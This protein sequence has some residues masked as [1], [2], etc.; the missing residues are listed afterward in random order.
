MFQL[1][2]GQLTVDLLD[3]AAP[4]DRARLGTRYCWGGYIWQVRDAQAGPLLAGPEWP[5]PTPIAFNGQGL[6]ESFRHAE[7]GTGRPLILENNRGFII[8]IG[9]V[10]LNMAGELAVEQPCAWTIT[11][12]ADAVEFCTAQSGHGH[13]CQLTRRIALAGRTL[14][15]STRLANTGARPLPLHWFAHPFFA[16]ADR[17]LTCG[18]PA[19]WG[20]ADNVGY[21]LDAQHRLAFQRRFLHR[22]DGHFE[23][24][25]VGSGTPL[26]AVLSHPRLTQIVFTTD[27]TPDTCPVWGNGNTWSI[28]P[29]IMSELAPG[30]TRAWTLR[31]E[32]G[33]A[34][35]T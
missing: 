28:E 20:M 35:G 2:H 10:A 25:R 29:Y 6:P 15:S 5:D 27:F 30:A 8:G 31:Y 4:A 17:L 13:A 11:P 1:R 3:P 7:F 22:D 32:F 18:L 19:N 34:T 23:Q 14:T 21:T 12:G 24:L 26:R 9:D 33:P 16:L